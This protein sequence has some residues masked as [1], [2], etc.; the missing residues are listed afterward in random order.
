MSMSRE[1]AIRRRKG[2]SIMIGHSIE[3]MVE[4][5]EGDQVRLRCWSPAILPVAGR[6]EVEAVAVENQKAALSRLP[7]MEDL[8][9][10]LGEE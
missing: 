6:E 4:A 9:L 10:L 7:T 3:V 5:I 1:T 8:C 2:E